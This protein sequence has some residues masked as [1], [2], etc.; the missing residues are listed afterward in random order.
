MVFKFIKYVFVKYVK[1]HFLPPLDIA[2]NNEKASSSLNHSIQS[3]DA[4]YF[5]KFWIYVKFLYTTSQG[6]GDS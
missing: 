3:Q 4:L 1:N 2:L 6:K 5:V